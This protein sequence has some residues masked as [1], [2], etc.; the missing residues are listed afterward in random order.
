MPAQPPSHSVRCQRPAALH[1]L[2]VVHARVEEARRT[3][4]SG[5]PSAMA[6]ASS[7]ARASARKAASSG[8]S[9]MS[10]GGT[11]TRSSSGDRPAA[12]RPARPRWRQMGRRP[13]DRS[14]HADPRRPAPALGAALTRRCPVCGQGHLFRRWFTMIDRCPRCGL[15]FERIEG[16]WTGDLGINTIVSFGALLLTLLGGFLAHLPRRHRSRRCWS[17]R[18]LVAVVVP[19]RVL[20]VLQDASGWPSTCRCAH[21]SPARCGAVPW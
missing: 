17:P 5:R 13:H 20:P 14:C 18:V 7:Q 15:R 3:Q 16:H 11:I 19:D 9:S 8:V 2:V 12:R 21:P 1:E 6:L 10:T 4:S